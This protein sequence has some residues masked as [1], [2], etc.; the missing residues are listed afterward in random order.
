MERFVIRPMTWPVLR[1]FSRNPLLRAS[2]RIDAA[3]VALAILAVVIAAACAGVL[4]TMVYDTRAQTYRAE[5]QTRHPVPAIAVEDSKTTAMPDATVSTV[6][7]RWHANGA[8]HADVLGCDEG[9][10]AGDPLQVWV[11]AHGNRVD[12]PTSIAC[13]GIDAASVAMVAWLSAVLAVT[14]A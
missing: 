13:A 6:H 3:V 11:D 4:G 7:A 9:V 5:A 8:D 1:L 12:A 10:K 14:L 2:D